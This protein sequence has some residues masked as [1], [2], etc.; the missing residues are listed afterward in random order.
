MMRRFL[1]CFLLIASLAFVSPAFAQ[2]SNGE[3]VV[4]A[5]TAADSGACSGSTSCVW[6]TFPAYMFPFN[7]TVAVSGTW[8]GTLTIQGNNGGVW[9]TIGT[10]TSNETVTTWPT[11]YTDVRV[12]ETAYTSGTANV[13][14]GR[15][16]VLPG[17]SSGTI[18]ISS[19]TTGTHTFTVP[20]AVTP[21]C[22]ANIVGTSASA[23]GVYVSPSTTAIEVAVS[24]SGTYTVAWSCQG[25]SN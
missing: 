22:N 24:S 21:V 23:L 12:L 3:T 17:E 4:G 6:M 11:Q 25:A 20:Y 9:T 18:S 5:L 7:T 16:A 10:T 8:A 15:Q 14:I 19:A 2:K 13:T 1:A